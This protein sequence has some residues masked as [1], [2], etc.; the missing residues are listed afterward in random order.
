M[1]LLDVLNETDA[2]V[3][4]PNT[5]SKTNTKVLIKKETVN[6]PINWQNI[7]ARHLLREHPQN[8]SSI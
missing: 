5:L 8:R 2:K 7:K 4:P 1:A 6:N 3:L